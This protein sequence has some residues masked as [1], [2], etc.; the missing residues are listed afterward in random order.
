MEQ[1]ALFK[2]VIDFQKN[3]FDNSFKAMAS[4]QKQ[5]EGILGVFLEQATWLPD[6]GKKAVTEWISAYE[7]GRDSF[8]ESV[9]KSF[10]K[11]EA[12]FAKTEN[13]PE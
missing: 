5:G 4:L 10:E 13:K 3:T 11:V 9:E 12:Y 1:K 2:Q 6:E 8:R 7:N